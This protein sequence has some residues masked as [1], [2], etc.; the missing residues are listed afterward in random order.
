VVSI[1]KSGGRNIIGRTQSVDET[2]DGSVLVFVE[3]RHGRA[4]PSRRQRI[5]VPSVHA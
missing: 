4:V 5:V 3:A 1:A 2:A